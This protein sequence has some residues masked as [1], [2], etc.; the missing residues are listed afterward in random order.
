MEEADTL[1]LVARAISASG[2]TVPDVEIVWQLLD[3]DSGQVGFTLD[4]ATGLVAA[5]HPGSGRVRPRAEELVFDPPIVITVTA[6]PDSAAAS[7]DVRVTLAA[8]ETV[9][10]SLNVEVFDLTTDPDTVQRIAD[11]SVMFALT[12]P[13]PGTTAADA[14]FL[15]EGDTVPGT[16]PHRVEVTTSNTGQASIVVHRIQGAQLPDSAIIHATVATALG[17]AVPT[18]PITFVVIFESN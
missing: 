17:N 9:S 11:K 18:S 5:T 2:D 7:G 3:V 6:A 10:P 12:E 1:Q 8:G 15:T 4:T 16:D 14:F 13:A